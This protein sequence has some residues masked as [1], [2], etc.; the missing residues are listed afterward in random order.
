MISRSQGDREVA[1][2]AEPR[3]A[4]LVYPIFVSARTSKR[5]Y[6]RTQEYH[7]L[8]EGPGGGRGVR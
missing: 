1:A 4:A 8:D 6:H 7:T 5:H 3:G 2:A